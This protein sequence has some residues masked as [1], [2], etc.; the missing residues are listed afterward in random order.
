MNRHFTVSIYVV[1]NNRVLLHKHKKAQILLPVGGHIELNEL[2][3]ET[4]KREALEE[5]GIEIELYDIDSLKDKNID[6]EREKV[7]INPI[8]TIWGEIEK[9][10]EHIDFV[11]YATSMTDELRPQED[12]S[13]NL[14]W[15][16]EKELKEIKDHLLKD[17][18]Y[19]AQ[20]AIELCRCKKK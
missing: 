12:E 2:P 8:H 17:V 11:F 16:S 19:M 4:A 5:T 15:Y 9:G 18:Y 6:N 1:N 13:L 14:R 7:L 10:H 20:E 3:E